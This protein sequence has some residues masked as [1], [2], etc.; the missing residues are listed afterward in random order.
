MRKWFYFLLQMDF[1]LPII[2][3]MGEQIMASALEAGFVVGVQLYIYWI[4]YQMDKDSE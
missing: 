1:Q 4:N 2:G 3:N